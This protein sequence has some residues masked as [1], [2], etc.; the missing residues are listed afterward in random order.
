MINPKAMTPRDALS[1]W[2]TLQDEIT[3]QAMQSEQKH[4]L[5]HELATKIRQGIDGGVIALSEV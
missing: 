4:L 5:I 3:Y 2:H 1:A